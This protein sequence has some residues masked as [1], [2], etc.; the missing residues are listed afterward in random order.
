MKVIK[1]IIL[2]LLMAFT[3][4]PA[5]ASV[6]GNGT[7]AETDFNMQEFIFGHIGDSYEW[8]I[9][10]I[11]DRH[12]SVPL[13]VI[14]ISRHSGAH[15]FL[16]SSLQHGHSYKGFRIAEEGDYA[17]KI[18]EDADGTEYRPLDISITKN[19]L[20]L[21][22]NAA[23][24]LFIILM[25]AR[26]YRRHDVL[27]EAP[28]GI[29]ALVEPVVEMIND[30]VIKD[31]VG[32]EHSRFA[33]YL[34]TV[35][36]FILTCNLMGIVPFFP[37]GT[38]LTGNIAITAVLALCTFLAV[39]IFGNRH[40]FKDIFWPDVPMFMKSP[41]LPLIQIIEL[42]GTLT[43]P[44]ALMVRLFANMLAGHILILSLVAVIF[45]TAKMGPVINGSLSVVTVLFGVFMD[46]LELLVAFIQAYV[47]TMLSSVF[48]GLAHN[49]E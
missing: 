14:L 26:W 34:L 13:P 37:G 9:T 35:F 27:K 16:S 10:T 25:S 15:C 23:I 45:L 2:I 17:G 22:I 30:D 5:S 44:F 7:Q 12:I 31:A 38:N 19:V 36:F 39:N 11:G 48:I 40:Y 49:E 47:F 24:L 41:L 29:A 32:R 6:S 1:C 21:M 3:M 43:K 4:S 28:T 46:C 20:S 33:P 42:F 8:H 18:V